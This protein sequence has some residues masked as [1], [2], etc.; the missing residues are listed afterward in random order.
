MDLADAHDHSIDDRPIERQANHKA[1]A[2]SR[3]ARHRH[4]RLPRLEARLD[5]GEI[6]RRAALADG[7]ETGLE[8]TVQFLRIGRVRRGA[9][10]NQIS[11]QALAVILDLDLDIVLARADPDRDLTRGRFAACLSPFRRFD[12][13]PRGKAHQLADGIRERQHGAAIQFQL[14]P[15]Q[16]QLDGFALDPGTNPG[17]GR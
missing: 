1:R 13:V 17:P 11:I 14:C 8:H 5:R 2:L 7:A 16:C 6:D 15:L 9:P 3:R 4:F 12:P 10:A